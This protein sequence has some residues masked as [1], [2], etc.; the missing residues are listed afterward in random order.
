MKHIFTCIILAVCLQAPKNLIKETAASHPVAPVQNLFIITIDGFR[1]QEIFNGADSLLINDE[2]YTPDTATMKMMYWASDP[3]E[4]RK[5]LMPFFWNV[6][7]QKGQIYGN[8]HFNNK[9]NVSNIYSLSYP[10]YSEMFTGK[11]DI[12]ISSNDKKINP[13]YNVLEYLNQQ[14]GYKGN[15]VAFTSWDVFPYIL[16]KQRA[17]IKM[18]S[19]YENV[20]EDSMTQSL[21][22]KIQNEEVYDKTQTRQDELTFVAAREYVKKFKPSIVY[23]GFGETDE[24]AHQGRYDLYLEKAAEIDKM[25]AQLWHW[26]Q[27]TPA[28]K[29]NTTF[30]ITTDHGRGKSSSKWINHGFFIN[31]SSQTWLALIGPNIT[32]LGE[33]KNDEQ[34]YQKQIAQTIAELVGKNFQTNK[35]VAPAIVLR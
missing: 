31:G 30:I 27:S 17:G 20:E 16:D 11:A 5:K 10:G 26:A 33:M 22:D 32:P 2:R 18:N 6:L 19:G 21:V 28:Y 4:R 24:M 35:V 9:V 12:T 25:I 14:A 13:N 23:L 7:S 29:N 8:R 1:W 3:D 15:V 34:I